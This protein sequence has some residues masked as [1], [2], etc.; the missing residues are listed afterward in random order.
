MKNECDIVKDLLFSYND[1][2]LSNTSKELVE[3]H[4]RNCEN[5]KN[6]LKEIENEKS[7]TNEI[8]EIDFLKKVKRKISIKNIVIGI[9]TVLLFIAIIF[10]LQVYNNYKQDTSKMEVFLKN[11]ITKEEIDNIKNKIAEISIDAKVTYITSEEQIEKLKEYFSDEL[12]YGLE[13][14]LPP[15]IEIKCKNN[16]KIQ[17]IVENIKSMPGIDSITT[18][19][20]HN[21]YE[22]YIT[23]IFKNESNK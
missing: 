5:C 17:L 15:T 12:M 7:K 23:K 6:I 4:L 2:V 20:N 19:I 18:H 21:P 13:D 14:V 1:G 22:L 11:D 8:K 16:N 3:E 10:N 9:I